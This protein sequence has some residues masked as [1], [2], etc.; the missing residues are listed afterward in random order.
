MYSGQTK[1]AYV[2]PE[3]NERTDTHLYYNYE[4]IKDASYKLD[5]FVVA[6][7]AEG[8]FNL[9]TPYRAQKH[10]K[11]FMRFFEIFWI[12]FSLRGK[13]YNNFYVHYSYYGNR[14]S[15]E[16]ISETL[17]SERLQNFV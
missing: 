16:R 11:G 1:I 5:I 17:Q 4:L 12:L 6:E 10:R 8:V 15:R 9:G 13:G 2:L 14:I 7:K 3:Y